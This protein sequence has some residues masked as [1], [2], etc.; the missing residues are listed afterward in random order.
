MRKQDSAAEAEYHKHHPL[1]SVAGAAVGAVAGAVVGTMGGPAGMAAGAV[2]GAVL[3]GIEGGV[4]AEGV[5]TLATPG[6]G[7][8][9]PAAHE[10]P[11]PDEGVTSPPQAA[12]PQAKGQERHRLIGARVA[13]RD[14]RTACSVLSRPASSISP[15]STASDASIRCG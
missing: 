5:D 14:Q 9:F 1:G 2:V 15:F 10:T 4:A 13:D 3:G 8:D 7:K 11:P 6:A 12:G